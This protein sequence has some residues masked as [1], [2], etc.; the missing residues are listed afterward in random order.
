[1]TPDFEKNSN[2]SLWRTALF[3]V[4]VLAAF[5]FDLSIVLGIA[6]GVPFLLLVMISLW[7]PRTSTTWIAA[8]IGTVLTVF[9][10]LSSAPSGAIWSNGLN[11]LLSVLAV[12]VTANLC[13]IFKKKSAQ[14]ALALAELKLAKESNEAKSQFLANMSHE[15]RTPMTA[16]LGFAD[17]LSRNVKLPENVEAVRII[18]RNGEHLLGLLN[19]ILDLSKIEAGKLQVVEQECSPWHIVSEVASLMRVRANAKGLKLDVKW[20]GSLPASIQSDPVR[21]RQILVNL[22][23]NA[24]KFTQTGTVQIAIQMIYGQRDEP[25]LQFEVSDTGIGITEE[26]IPQLF[27]PFTQADNSTHRQFGGTGL[28]LAIC[29][30][31]TDLL[32][33]TISVSSNPGKGTTFTFSLPISLLDGVELLEHP[34]ES[35]T[36]SFFEDNSPQEDAVTLNSRVL[37]AEDC[38]D[39]QRLI[40]LLLN[41]AGADVTVAKNGKVALRLASKALSQGMPFDV[42]LMD[43]QMPVQDGYSTTRILRA[44]GYTGPII[45]LTA[46]AM[47]GDQE[48]C[49]Q[50]GCDDY[51]TKPIDRK[52]L[53]R[54]VEAFTN[55]NTKQESSLALSGR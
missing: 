6:G 15:I 35:A 55:Q 13:V 54:M 11:L 28:G 2:S 49:I 48:K 30:R 19:D 24:I 34:D 46:N 22:V 20:N 45:A 43:M 17:V 18:Q 16:I 38:P 14:K 50:A 37:L 21:I 36:G 12:W 5:T 53:I 52:R 29:K 7:S 33:G 44:E 31:L 39:N 32:A 10:F 3:A 8:L 26:Q 42:I 51:M 27:Q 1:M 4:T 25:V 41:K 47:V 23:G 40:S 9:G